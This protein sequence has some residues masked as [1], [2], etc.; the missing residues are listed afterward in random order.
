MNIIFKN[1]DLNPAE[2]Y[3]LTASPAVQKLSI[4][5]GKLDLDALVLAERTNGEGEIVKVLFVQTPEHECYATNSKSA[6]Q[7]IEDIIACYKDS[8]TFPQS[9]NVIH[10]QSKA[11]RTYIGITL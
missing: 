4:V 1:R 10:R 3:N 9:F 5:D 6:I 8:G 7:N 2:L 11:G